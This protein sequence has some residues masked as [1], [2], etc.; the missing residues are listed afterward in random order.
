LGEGVE[1]LVPEFHCHVIVEALLAAGASVSYFRVNERGEVDLA[2]VERRLTARTRALVI[3]H[4]FGLPQDVPRIRG[5]CDE[6]HLF[7]V[8]DCAHSLFGKIENRPLGSWGD[9]AIFSVSKTIPTIDGG[10]MLA[11]NAEIDSGFR[12]RSQGLVT[13]AKGF[14]KSMMLLRIPDPLRVGLLKGARA[15]RER[16]LE[17]TAKNK[18]VRQTHGSLTKSFVLEESSIDMHPIS[19]WILNRANSKKVME[20][21]RRNYQY[22]AKEL[23]EGKLFSPQFPDLS[24]GGCPYVFPVR[25]SREVKKVHRELV[26]MGVPVLVFP[27][28][29]RPTQSL[30]EFRNA[31]ELANSL[32]CLPCHHEITVQDIEKMVSVLWKVEKFLL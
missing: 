6:R 13:V 29:L 31:Y 15:V 7:L 10:L 27:D 25:V 8:E 4:Y 30:K 18:K 14:F 24:A 1:V 21:R 32:L 20:N 23:Q 19:K 11:N 22:L 12:V 9:V 3:I 28:Q 5:W 26:R 17:N 16:F 2:D